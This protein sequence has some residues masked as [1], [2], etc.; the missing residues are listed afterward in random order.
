M[1]ASSRSFVTP[2]VLGLCCVVLAVL[3]IAGGAWNPLKVLPRVFFFGLSMGPLPL[4]FMVG[5]LL[6]VGSYLIQRG[7]E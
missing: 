5:G 4:L 7:D 2:T 1:A 3:M 6:W